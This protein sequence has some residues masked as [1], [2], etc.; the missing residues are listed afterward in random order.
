[1]EQG[2]RLASKKESKESVILAVHEREGN[3]G[4]SPPHVFAGPAAYIR[5]LG[6]NKVAHLSLELSGFGGA[7]VTLDA[8][9]SVQ[10]SPNSAGIVADAIRYAQVAAELGLVGAVHGASALLFKHP[11]TQLAFKDAQA[12][13]AL[14]AARFE[15]AGCLV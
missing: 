7:R 4:G 11:P 8:K 3:C 15:R 1:M 6:D 12:A 5:H 10:D 14:L 9:L 2:T 13:C